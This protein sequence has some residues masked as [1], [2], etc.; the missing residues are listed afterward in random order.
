MISSLIAVALTCHLTNLQ[1]EDYKAVLKPTT[2]KDQYS[3][4]LTYGF[5]G[6]SFD[7]KYVL[8]KNRD[9]LFGKDKKGETVLVKDIKSKNLDKVTLTVESSKEG[10]I[11]MTCEKLK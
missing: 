5:Y 2:V 4:V 8:N 10:T 11:Y 3:F 6:A 7:Y 9:G 1:P